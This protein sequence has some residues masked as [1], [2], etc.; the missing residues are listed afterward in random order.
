MQTIL[1]WAMIIFGG[2]LYL[3]QLISSINFSLAQKL[4]LQEN[5][6]NTDSLLIR[7]EK[8]VAYWDLVVLIWFPVSGFLMLIKHQWW[9]IF[10]IFAGAIYLDAAGREAFK[11]L[12]FKHHGLKVG[13]QKQW[14]LFFATYIFMASL[15]LLVITHSLIAL[16]PIST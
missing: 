14:I 1:A 6:D 2:A 5:P 16:H 8:Y 11:N 13:N 4:G 10:S 7:S 12:S 15:A 3:A 9:P